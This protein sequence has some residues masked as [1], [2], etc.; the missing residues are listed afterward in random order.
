M[1]SNTPSLFVGVIAVACSTALVVGIFLLGCS[2][3][4]TP[5][6]DTTDLTEADDSADPVD[7]ETPDDG[8][9]SDDTGHVAAAD[10]SQEGD[11]DE[12][13]ADA[14]MQAAFDE[15]NKPPVGPTVVKKITFDD[16]E[17]KN[18]E[19]DDIFELG[20][21]DEN[22][23]PLIGDTVR[24]TGDIHAG[25]LMSNKNIREFVL[26]INKECLFGRGGTAWHNIRVQLKEGDPLTYNG[27]T[28]TVEG[29]L[30]LSIY[31]GPGIDGQP[32]T[33][34]IYVLVGKKV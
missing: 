1:Q 3:Q 14:E 11:G 10:D 32:T 26:V 19:P 24:I 23:E 16:L 12:T 27:E 17:L 30:T 15:L 6:G 31:E 34:S 2:N 20:D 22:V 4:P 21:L 18:L 9:P 28:V 5:I 8:E 25:T 7:G 33:W 29:K 13:S